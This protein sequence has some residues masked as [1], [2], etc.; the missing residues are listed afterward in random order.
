MDTINQRKIAGRVDGAV[1]SGNSLKNCCLP[2]LKDS[3]YSIVFWK[4]KKVNVSSA[5]FTFFGQVDK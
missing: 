5:V 3:L 1:F 4:N 2:A